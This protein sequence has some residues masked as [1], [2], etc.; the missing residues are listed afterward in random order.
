M[1]VSLTQTLDA[2]LGGLLTK[3]HIFFFLE[4]VV[5]TANATSVPES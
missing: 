4:N 5:S 2:R 3:L 1:G